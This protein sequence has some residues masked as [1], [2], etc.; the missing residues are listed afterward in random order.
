[1]AAP[2]APSTR[3]ADRAGME[4]VLGETGIDLRLDDNRSGVVTTS[5]ESRLTRACYWADA[6]VTGFYLSKYDP[7]GLAANWA[8]YHWCNVFAVYRICPRRGNAVPSSIGAMYQETVELL[9]DLQA[10]RTVL[11]NVAQ[12]GSP[13]ISVSNLRLDGRYHTR[14]LRVQP[15][16][17]DTIRPKHDQSKDWVSAVVPEHNP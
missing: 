10:G 13:S 14:Q 4:D 16:I 8:V 12:R 17:S 1:M 9:V 15:T 7:T 2:S 3:L 11:S 6:M 5:E